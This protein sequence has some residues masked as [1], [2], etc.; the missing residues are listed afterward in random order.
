MEEIYGD[1]GQSGFNYC[2]TSIRFNT[3]FTYY[4]D[5]N[6]QNGKPDKWYVTSGPLS[7][8]NNGE[9]VSFY[10]PIVTDYTN[11]GPISGFPQF[12]TATATSENTNTFPGGTIAGNGTFPA[13]PPQGQQL[14]ATLGFQYAGLQHVWRTIDN[15]GPE[16][17]L[18]TCPEFTTSGDDPRCGD[19]Q[20]L[21]DP[22]Y[23]APGHK[24]G[25]EPGDLTSAQYGG[26]RLA[27]TVAAVE[28]NPGNSNEL[29][30]ATSFGRVFVSFNVNN[31]DPKTVTFCRLDSLALSSTVVPPPRFV[32]SI[33]PDPANPNRAWL[34]YDGYSSNTK[35]QPG[36]VFEVTFAGAATPT[37]PCPTVAVW[38]DLH[39][40]GASA[41]H[42]DPAGDIPITDLV[43][44]DFT[45]DLYAAT[46]FGVLRDPGGQDGTWTEAGPGLPRVEVPGLTIDPCSRILYAATHGRSVWR[47]FLPAVAAAKNLKGCPRTP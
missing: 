16:A 34:S 4:T 1:G 37:S 33:Y 47:M 25:G 29:W 20:P 22:L 3:F 6:F 11:C 43:R 2:D 12:Q 21:G 24:T 41:T 40:E 32:S 27:G 19:W 44:D 42:S 14:G 31:V 38:R 5:E 23:T 46:D 26:D 13:T 9:G 35:D 36:H 10:M 15:G 45:G 17:Y 30:A 8:L 7:S 18:Q 28:R 39:V